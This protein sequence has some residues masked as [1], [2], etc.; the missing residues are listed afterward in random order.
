M[1]SVTD[2]KYY[3]L[4]TPTDEQ[5]A[6]GVGI[7][8]NV[9]LWIV[10]PDGLDGV[11]PEVYGISRTGIQTWLNVGEVEDLDEF[12][13]IG[14]FTV[15]PRP[16]R[17][18][19]LDGGGRIVMN[20]VL[21]DDGMV[22][23]YELWKDAR[24]HRLEG[25]PLPVFRYYRPSGGFTEVTSALVEAG[26]ARVS[27]TAPPPDEVGWWMIQVR[28]IERLTLTPSPGQAPDG[29]GGYRWRRRPTPLYMR[30]R[31]DVMGESA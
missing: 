16:Y 31:E 15:P 1:P 29:V 7:T 17:R 3:K 23:Y 26:K 27:V 9:L 22:Q 4:G 18:I 10:E 12:S 5:D 13:G 25:F 30:V 6:S 28:F 11:L 24:R 8:P 2:V 14:I 21:S 19:Q 20:A